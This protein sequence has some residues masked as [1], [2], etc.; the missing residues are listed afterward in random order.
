MHV[1][2]RNFRAF[3][4]RCPP[5]ALY[6]F[7]SNAFFIRRAWFGVNST[8]WG[9]WSGPSPSLTG[10]TS[11]VSPRGLNFSSPLCLP[12]PPPGPF[13]SSIR[14]IAPTRGCNIFLRIRHRTS[15][16]RTHS[17]GR[18]PSPVRSNDRSLIE[19]RGD[20]GGIRALESKW[21]RGTGLEPTLGGFA[22]RR[23]TSLPPRR[24]ICP[25][26]RPSRRLPGSLKKTRVVSTGESRKPRIDAVGTIHRDPAR[27]PGPCRSNHSDRRR[28]CPSE[29]RSRPGRGRAIDRR[30]ARPL[31]HSRPDRPARRVTSSRARI[32]TRDPDAR[33]KH[34]EAGV[35]IEPA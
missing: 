25:A 18:Q 28:R 11:G 3:G 21:R 6:A 8:N 35:G 12:I 26:I 2:A 22:I 10:F 15:D 16:G 9:T 1:R 24:V 13:G 20:P 32:G 19:I 33:R 34:L 17:I 4:L 23:I 27:R 30:R 29:A 14:S 7:P 31:F 5:S